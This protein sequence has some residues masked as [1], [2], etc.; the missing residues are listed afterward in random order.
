MLGNV[1]EWTADWYDGDYYAASAETDPE[2]P[3]DG[4]WR[5]VR[6]GSFNSLDGATWVYLRGIA[7]PEE[8]YSFVGFR[9]VRDAFP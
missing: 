8:V 5:V 9:C 6:G 1:W 7:D 3:P 2:G 4:E